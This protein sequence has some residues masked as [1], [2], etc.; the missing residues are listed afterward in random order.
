[1]NYYVMKPDLTPYDG[2]K[3][4]KDTC[5]TFENEKVKQEIKNLKLKSISTFKSEK[6][7]TKSE[8][9]VNLEEGEILLLEQENRG[10]FLPLN[11]GICTINE[12]IKDY[13]ALNIA[14]NGDDK[15]DTKGNEEQSTKTN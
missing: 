10:Y 7:S 2:V 14:L 9:E 12:A 5:L 3:V 13:E 8:L 1:M 6:Y 15:N 4:T 11:V